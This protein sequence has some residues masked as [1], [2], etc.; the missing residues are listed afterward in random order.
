MRYTQNDAVKKKIEKWGALV[1]KISDKYSRVRNKQERTK[2]EAKNW[3]KGG[4]D[5]GS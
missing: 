2:R 1:S 3:P 4:Y 5:D